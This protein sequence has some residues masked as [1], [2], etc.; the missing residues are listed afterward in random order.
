MKHNKDEF[1]NKVV[2]TTRIWVNNFN[3]NTNNCKG[4]T[5][6]VIEVKKAAN[7]LWQIYQ[8]MNSWA[9]AEAFKE[10]K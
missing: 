7:D 2:E 10:R 3:E 4:K 9:D 6:L 8:A 5:Q 1:C